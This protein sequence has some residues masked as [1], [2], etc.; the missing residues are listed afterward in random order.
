MESEWECSFKRISER[1]NVV[2]LELEERLTMG[3][4]SSAVNSISVYEFDGDGKVDH[5][6]IYLQM[7][8]PGAEM[9]ESYEGIQITE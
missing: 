9:L 3:D 2:I 6:D 4:F 7:P 1:D 5:L 8:L